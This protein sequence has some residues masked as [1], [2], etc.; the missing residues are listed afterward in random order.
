MHHDVCAREAVST[1]ELSCGLREVVLKKCA[2]ALQLRV[3]E[4][5]LYFAANAAGDGLQEERYWG[6]LDVCSLLSRMHVEPGLG[7]THDDQADDH[8][9]HERAFRIV[10]QELRPD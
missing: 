1:E 10:H 3:N 7:P 8:D 9:G 2:V 4:A 5:G 6:I